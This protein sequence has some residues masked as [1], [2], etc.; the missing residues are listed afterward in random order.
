M[1]SF[2]FLKPCI[3]SSLISS[4]APLLKARFLFTFCFAFC[5]SV[6]AL[7]HGPGHEKIVDIT[8]LLAENGESP[9]L[10]AERA[11]ILQAN[12]HWQDAMA[13]FNKAAELDPDNVEYDLDRAY[14]SYDAGEYQLGLDFI[15]LYLLRH[16]ITAEALLVKA[17][18][19]RA[20]KQ[21]QQATQLYQAAL[22][23]ISTINSETSP[24]WYLEFADTLTKTGDKQQALKVLQ[25]GI[26]QIGEISV[27]QV[28]A[29]ELEVDLGLYNA[30]L[31][32]IDQLL[33]MSQR[34]DIWLSRRADILSRAGQHKEAQ[35]T[36]EQAYAALQSL[37]ERLQ[38]LPVSKE[39]ENTLLAHIAS[40]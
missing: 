12:Q 28:K 35:Q 34:K 29:A 21:Y 2:R 13:D 38:N 17:R 18:S 16:E 1:T 39:L 7:A 6:P 32:R 5:C 22:S 26:K 30:A 27:F 37:P 14:L 15:D 10:Y 40:E 3:D 20:L 19:Y 33:A 11:R 24:E 31:K 25:Q 36:Y 23:D 4:L 8:A 9:E